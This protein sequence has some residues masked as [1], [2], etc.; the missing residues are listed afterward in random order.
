MQEGTRDVTI[1]SY[2]NFIY[3]ARRILFAV[4]IAA[5]IS[6]TSKIQDICLITISSLMLVVLIILRPYSDHLRNIIHIANEVGLT[7]IGGGFL[8]Y[9]HYVDILEPIGT[10]I[11]CGTIITIVIIIHLSIALIWSILRTYYFYR[12]L[13][14]DFKE[15]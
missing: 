1:C 14:K 12:E 8:Y 7:F 2:I 13:Y 4:V 5:T 11:L 3:Y 6:T 15:T 10:K 9:K